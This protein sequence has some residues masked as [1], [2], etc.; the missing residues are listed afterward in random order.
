MDDYFDDLM[1]NDDETITSAP[2]RMSGYNIYYD[3]SGVYVRMT[4]AYEGTVPPPDAVRLLEPIAIQSGFWPVL[5]ADKTGF[6]Q[7]PD[8]RGQ[9]WYE[10]D[11]TS[12]LIDY[13]GDPAERGLLKEKPAANEDNA[14]L[15]YSCSAAQAKIVL[16][17]MPS[18][19]DE[20]ETMLD[21][22][23]YIVMNA[24][25]ATQIWYENAGNWISNDPYVIEFAGMIG[26]TEEQIVDL[27]QEAAKL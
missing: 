1:I 15:I 21:L 12:V 10:K 8:H 13:L 9:T 25:R 22:V 5:N 6:D 17:Q 18:P 26:L 24:D 16:L 2:L 23:E 19:I 3:Q 11:G 14:P 4:P 7:I 27:F 20:T